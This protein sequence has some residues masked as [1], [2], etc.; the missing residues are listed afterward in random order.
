MAI[1]ALRQVWISF[2][3]CREIAAKRYWQKLEFALESEKCGKSV[4]RCGLEDRVRIFEG[5]LC[6]CRVPICEYLDDPAGKDLD[7]TWRAAGAL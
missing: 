6:N 5:A 2:A 7:I 1:C 3:S 4:A